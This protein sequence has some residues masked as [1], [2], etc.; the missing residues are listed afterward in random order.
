MKNKK[1]LVSA[2]LGVS[3]LAI[4]AVVGIAVGKKSGFRAYADPVQPEW[5][6][7]SRREATS[8]QIGIREYWVQCGGS[9]QFAAPEDVDIVDKGSSYDLSEFA[10]FDNRYFAYSIDEHYHDFAASLYGASMLQKDGENYNAA[11]YRIN[12]KGD[13]YLHY[14]LY[15]QDQAETFRIK[16]P[17]IDYRVYPHVHMDLTCP[18]WNQNNYFG[19][20][21]DDLTYTTVYGG[22]KDQGK[23]EFVYYDGTLKMDFYDPEHGS[24]W[25]TKTYTDTDIINGLASPCFYV[26]NRWDRYM[27]IDNITLSK[28]VDDGNGYCSS[29]HHV[30]GGT[31]VSSHLFANVL[32]PNSNPA[33]PDGFKTSVRQTAKHNTNTYVESIGGLNAYSRLYFAVYSPINLRFFSGGGSNLAF[34]SNCWNYIYMINQDG[35]QDW[36]AYGRR[37]GSSEFVQLVI[38]N[39][40]TNWKWMFSVCACES[41]NTS[42]EFELFT[43][44]LVGV[45]A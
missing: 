3:T 24:L 34:W 22:N 26:T 15:G 31:T 10:E 21:D 30:I 23:I 43:T 4:G 28:H 19:P 39:K 2:L 29:C 9:Y 6:H 33:A 27:N 40:S 7:Y 42:T 14:S 11:D 41:E 17:R 32:E 20:E 12:Q 18:D 36:V 35:N 45:P 37:A 13:S 44:E 1:L 38:D 25:F 5:H 16:L 8:S